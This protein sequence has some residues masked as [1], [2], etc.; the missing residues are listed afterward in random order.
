[1][2]LR[3]ILTCP[4]PRLAQKSTPVETV[5][6]E[7]KQ[8]IEDMFET[9]YT[10][11]GVGLAA[12]QVGITKRVIVVDC[13]PRGEEAQESPL[14]PVEP[15]AIVNPVVTAKE[16]RIT[17]EEGCLSI[18]GFVDDVERAAVITVEGLDREG[19]PLSMQAEGLL[20]VCIQHEIDHLEGVLFVDRLSRLKQ[21]LVK[22]K[23]KK[24][25]R[26]EARA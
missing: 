2:A 26:E 25:A 21:T 24:K 8:L 9:M 19:N 12:P 7:I 17:W 5:D 13:G 15:L 1:M 22:K 14:L 16:G 20:A 3:E 6:D 4:D 11:E 10:A 18:P 23:L